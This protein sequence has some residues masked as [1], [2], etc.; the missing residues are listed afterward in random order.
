MLLH[1]LNLTKLACHCH[2]PSSTE[3][4][5]AN[6]LD[7]GPPL[8]CC[9]NGTREDRNGHEEKASDIYLC[10]PVHSLQKEQLAPTF[11]P[12]E[13]LKTPCSSPLPRNVQL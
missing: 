11:S 4:W 9:C 10:G 3:L 2:A 13:T 12:Q 6:R 7:N 5:A 8:E 1:F